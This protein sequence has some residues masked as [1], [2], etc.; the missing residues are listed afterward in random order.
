MSDPCSVT[1]AAEP[2]AGTAPHTRGWLVLEH[3]GPYARIATDALGDLA[4]PLRRACKDAGVT[5]L[6]AVAPF[7]G[8]P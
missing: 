4:E 6:L 1:A 3:P 2:L 7:R 5:M 8:L